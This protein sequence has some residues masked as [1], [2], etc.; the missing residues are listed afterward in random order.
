MEIHLFGK[1]P[2]S[3]NLDQHNLLKIFVW[4]RFID[5]E[6]SYSVLRGLTMMMMMQ[7]Q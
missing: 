4:E 1:T 6:G 7:R 3:L 2:F 5:C